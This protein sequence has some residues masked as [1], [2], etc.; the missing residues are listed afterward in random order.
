MNNFTTL[1]IA[2]MSGFAIAS[3]GSALKFIPT[4]IYYFFKRQFTVTTTIRSG[5][6]MY[7]LVEH[8]IQNNYDIKQFR[9]L[10]GRDEKLMMGWSTFMIKFNHKRM[11]VSSFEDRQAHKATNDDQGIRYFIITTFGRKHNLIESFIKA[12]SEYTNEKYDGFIKTMTYDCEMQHLKIHKVNER[13]MDSIVMKKDDKEFLLE[14]IR[15]FIENE[16]FYRDNCIPYRLGIML[17]GPPGTGKTS[18]I[19]AIATEFKLPINNMVNLNG[20]DRTALECKS[21]NVIEDID[22]YSV[23][24]DREEESSNVV[25]KEK[26]FNIATILNTLDGITS[27]DDYILIA[28]TNHLNKLDEALIR[29]GRF[30]VRIELGYVD[31]EMLESFIKFHFKEDVD[32]SNYIIKEKVTAS[33]L[34]QLVLERFTSKKIIDEVCI[35]HTGTDKYECTA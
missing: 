28:T 33:Y 18:L 11:I 35:V 23:V 7:Y 10:K 32:L 25:I 2:S 16:S 30:D 15:W 21:L 34:Q 29:P 5:D 31:I 3:L 12:C 17:Y 6:Y 19:K 24:K 4:N 26:E 20:M 27:K 22:S 13:P 1:L 14:Q 8:Y 9:I